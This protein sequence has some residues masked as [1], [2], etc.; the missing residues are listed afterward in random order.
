M[1][2]HYKLCLSL[3]V[4]A[5]AATPLD[6]G[7]DENSLLRLQSAFDLDDHGRADFHSECVMYHLER[8]LEW[9]LQRA[10]S[11]GPVKVTLASMPAKEGCIEPKVTVDCLITTKEEK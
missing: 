1:E 9:A 11:S 2:K 4:F 8:V 7:T 3:D 6:I 5:K 10:A